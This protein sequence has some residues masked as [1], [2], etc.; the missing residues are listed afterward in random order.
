MTG[1]IFKCAICGNIVEMLHHGGGTLVCCGE[2]MKLLVELT[3]DSSLEK[4]VPLIERVEG[5]Y[6]VKVGSVPH[7][8]IENHFI[9]WIELSAGE[10]KCRRHLQPGQV[11]EAFFPG[12][13]AAELRAREYCN[14][15]GLW[16]GEK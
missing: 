16:K 12:P 2:P 11:P 7:P 6:L 9:E 1:G 13:A 5:G 8:M 3:A 14:I 10:G 15:H 4:H